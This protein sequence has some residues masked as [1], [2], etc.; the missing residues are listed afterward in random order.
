MSH[1]QF[2]QPDR[3]CIVVVEQGADW[4]RSALGGVPEFGQVAIV[5]ETCAESG[6]TL[7][8]RVA[9]RAADQ[10]SAGVDLSTAV[11]VC[12]SDAPDRHRGRAEIAC[13]LARLLAPGPD[14]CLVL[15]TR[16]SG[17]DR[18]HELV[19]LAG[20][21]LDAYAGKALCVRV[22]TDPELVDNRLG[23]IVSPLAPMGCRQP[24]VRASAQYAPPG[25]RGEAP[26]VA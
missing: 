4:P 1:T 14:S 24:V 3:G 25:A 17:A 6:L 26:A 21:V 5:P 8:E 9:R 7:P 15:T 20:A 18:G 23:E 19:S 10:A 2:R 16:G 11:L 12:S 22:W 13:T